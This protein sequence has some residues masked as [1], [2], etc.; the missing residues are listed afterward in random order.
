MAVEAAVGHGSVEAADGPDADGE[1]L[2]LQ[3]AP[4]VGVAPGLGLQGRRLEADALR[5]GLVEPPLLPGP[6]PLAVLPGSACRG[7]LSR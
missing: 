2:G 5:L 4:G 3:G 1:G 6:C 7:T